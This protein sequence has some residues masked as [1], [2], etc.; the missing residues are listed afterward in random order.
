MMRR[1]DGKALLGNHLDRVEFWCGIDEIVVAHS[2]KS[3]IDVNAS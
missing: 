3:E 1:V 2:E